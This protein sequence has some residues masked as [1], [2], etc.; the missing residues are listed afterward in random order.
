MGDELIDIYDSK[1]RPLNKKVMKSEAHKKGLWHRVAHVWIYNSNKEV[2]LQLRSKDKEVYPNVWDISV[3]GHIST[4]EREIQ[5]AMR[6]IEEEI[7]LKVKESELK[8][9]NIRN[10]HFTTSTTI[11]NEIIYLYLLKY[12]GNIKQLKIQEEELQEIKFFKLN[13]LE[14]QLKEMPEKFTPYGDYFYE[15]IERIRGI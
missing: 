9:W 2:L 15:I 11:N 8:L 5:S 6:E 13:E 7:G 3:A 1:N 10:V 12:N 4:G 14:K